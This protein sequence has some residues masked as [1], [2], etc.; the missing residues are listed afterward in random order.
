M[1]NEDYG[2]RIDDVANGPEAQEL[3]QGVASAADVY[4]SYLQLHGVY[5]GS[6]TV[7]N[8]EA[9]KGTG[10]TISKYIDAASLERGGSLTS[11]H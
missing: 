9:P 3:L 4:F 11:R 5:V 1:T 6:V 2:R 7:A 10:P 8:P